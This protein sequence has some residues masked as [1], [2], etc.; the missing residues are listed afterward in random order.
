MGLG[1][2]GSTASSQAL[3]MKA[4]RQSWILDSRYCIPIFVSGTWS[5]DQ[6]PVGL[7]I[8]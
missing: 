4:T 8:P 1:V 3:E 2:K 5:Q 6:S 7:Q